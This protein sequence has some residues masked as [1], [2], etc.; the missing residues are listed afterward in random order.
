MLEILNHQ[1]LNIREVVTPTQ[2]AI[3]KE[4]FAMLNKTQLT[5]SNQ[6]IIAEVHK[7]DLTAETHLLDQSYQGPVIFD[8]EGQQITTNAING[9]AE[10]DFVV[11]AGTGTHTVGTA[12]ELWDNGEVVINA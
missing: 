7:F 1:I 11:E 12:N 10:I 4:H 6:K 2:T 5:Y 3:I 8:Y 9:I